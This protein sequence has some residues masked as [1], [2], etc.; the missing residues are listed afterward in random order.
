[1]R[2]LQQALAHTQRIRALSRD[3]ELRLPFFFV[4]LIIDR[5][6]KEPNVRFETYVRNAA[7]YTNDY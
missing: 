5:P 3:A 4:D 7:R 6:A 1:M 2:W